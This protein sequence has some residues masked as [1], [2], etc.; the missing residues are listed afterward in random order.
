LALGAGALL[1]A[2]LWKQASPAHGFV[3]PSVSFG[4]T[5]RGEVNAV[6]TGLSGAF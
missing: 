6:Y 3:R 2:L 5:P 1:T 4:G